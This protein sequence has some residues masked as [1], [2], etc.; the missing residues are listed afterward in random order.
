MSRINQGSMDFAVEA[1][2]LLRD[3]PEEWLYRTAHYDYR[4][5][6]PS[7]IGWM[8]VRRHSYYGDWALFDNGSF[9]AN[10]DGPYLKKLY[11]AREAEREQRALARATAERV[12]A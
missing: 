9:V 7:F 10:F 5:E 1:F 4:H 12:A 6:S 11:E 2:G 3:T 8:M